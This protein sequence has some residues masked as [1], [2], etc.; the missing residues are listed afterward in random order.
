MTDQTPLIPQL[1]EAQGPVKNLI[2]Y[3]VTIIAVPLIS[4]FLLKMFLFQ[5][6]LGYGHDDAVLYSAICA[7]VLVHVVLLFWIFS[8]TSAPKTVKK[9]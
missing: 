1:R 6:I 4:M 8:A 9:D 5:G 7:V 3:S 2:V